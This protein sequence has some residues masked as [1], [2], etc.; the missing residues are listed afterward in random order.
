MTLIFTCPNSVEGNASLLGV[1]H[2]FRARQSSTHHL[3]RHFQDQHEHN[4]GSSQQA[5]AEDFR[6]YHTPDR[7]RRVVQDDNSIHT[8][9]D[10]DDY[11]DEDA[12]RYT[13]K[14]LALM[15]S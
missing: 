12:D 5:L 9:S 7:S 11:Y 1:E 2:N 3:H 13:F 15:V 8:N 4:R 6:E 10:Y 14:H